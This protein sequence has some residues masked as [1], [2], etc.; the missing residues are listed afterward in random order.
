MSIYQKNDMEKKQLALNNGIEE[1]AY[2]VLN[3]S[4]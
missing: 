1:E 4:K 2:V 3:C